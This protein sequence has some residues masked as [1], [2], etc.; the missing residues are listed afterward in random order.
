MPAASQRYTNRGI[1]RK[2]R[3]APTWRQ[4]VSYRA[5][6]IALCCSR[7][8][9]EVWPFRP[10]PGSDAYEEAIRGG[11]QPPRTL[12]EWGRAEDYWTDEAWPG[13]IAPDVQHARRM[14]MFYS[15]LAQGRVRRRLGF[16][17]RRARRRLERNDFR[18]GLLEAR[19]FH[20]LQRLAG[21]RE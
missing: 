3:G 6:Q 10:L 21:R 14:F 5:R 4:T 1:W 17:E 20:W 13:R 19:L 12:E 7:V 9:P 16:W 15:S 11:F 2:R 8:R 18:F